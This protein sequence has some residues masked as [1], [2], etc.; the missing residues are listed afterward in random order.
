MA[1]ITYILAPHIAWLFTMT[2]DSIRI[3]AD[4]INFLRI[5]CIFYPAVS[6]GMLSS[7]M[8]QGTGKGTYSLV[9]TITRAVILTTPLAYIMAVTL[10]MQLDGLWWGIVVGNSTGALIAFIWGRTYVRGLLAARGAGDDH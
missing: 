1:T 4:L 6:P 8:F 10:G 7:A 5:M 9:L 3:R 2:Q